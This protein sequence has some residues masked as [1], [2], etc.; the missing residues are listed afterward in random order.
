M[1]ELLWTDDQAQALLDLEFNFAGGDYKVKKI[2]TG[3]GT[4]YCMPAITNAHHSSADITVAIDVLLHT[5]YST[6][7]KHERTYEQN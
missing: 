1:K 6:D 7:K 5:P 4:A 2:H 3:F